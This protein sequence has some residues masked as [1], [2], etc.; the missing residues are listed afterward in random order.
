ML[1]EDQVETLKMI[2]IQLEMQ[3]HF[4]EMFFKG[5]ELGIDNIFDIA[6]AIGTSLASGFY[7]TVNFEDSSKDNVKDFLSDLGKTV[8]QSYIDKVYLLTDGNEN[9]DMFVFNVDYD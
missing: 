3:K 7:E 9:N 8:V 6:Y 2:N 1:T 4:M 5:H